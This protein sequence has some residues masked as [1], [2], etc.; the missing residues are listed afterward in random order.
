M[1]DQQKCTP[2]PT[3]SPFDPALTP[4][5]WE[6]SAG[7]RETLLFRFDQPEDR[8]AL[9]HVA[10]L[11]HDSALELARPASFSPGGGESST[12]EELRAVAADLRHAQGFLAAVART[13]DESELP[14][15]DAALAELAARQAREVAAVATALER[16]LG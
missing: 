14:P 1:D 15:A 12:R 10:R 11:L 3:P 9:R 16:A 13:R 2:D 4:A 8:G 6:E 5:G 7:F